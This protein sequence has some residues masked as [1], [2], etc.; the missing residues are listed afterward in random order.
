MFSLNWRRAWDTAVRG[1][2]GVEGCC[3]NAQTW[4]CAPSLFSKLQKNPPTYLISCVF[5]KQPL[6]LLCPVYPHTFRARPPQ[7]MQGYFISVR[8]VPE[9]PDVLRVSP[10]PPRLLPFTNTPLIFP[11]NFLPLRKTME[12]YIKGPA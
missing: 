11:F 2:V 4:M 12:R 10:R 7:V 9:N 6:L 5:L 1:S 8:R 3:R